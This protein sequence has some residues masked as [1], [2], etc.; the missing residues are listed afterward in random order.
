M[1]LYRNRSDQVP[2]EGSKDACVCQYTC[3]DRMGRDFNT[4]EICWHF[5]LRILPALRRR[6]VRYARVLGRLLPGADP[7]HDTAAT[8]QDRQIL[9]KDLTTG[10]LVTV[11]PYQQIRTTL[12]KNGKCKGL[13]FMEGM[14]TYSNTTGRVLKEPLYVLDQGGEKIHKCRDLVILEDLYCDGTSIRCDRCC[15]YYWKKD[16]LK[17]VP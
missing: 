3:L 2:A 12:N 14:K 13:S 4:A 10:D 15:L 7:S 11:L 9:H 1:S 16:W 8:I 6:I 5:M 17:E